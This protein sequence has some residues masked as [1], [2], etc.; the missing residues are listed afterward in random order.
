[1]THLDARKIVIEALE[2][3]VGT[4]FYS[5]DLKENLLKENNKITIDQLE[6]D[7][8]SKMELCIALEINYGIEIVPSELENFG[9]FDQFIDNIIKKVSA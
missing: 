9:T 8:L 2:H 6:L 5:P 1:M 3:V 7:S 4:M